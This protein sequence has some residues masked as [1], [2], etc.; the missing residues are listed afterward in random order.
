MITVNKNLNFSQAIDESLEKFSLARKRLFKLWNYYEGRHD[1]L[2]RARRGALPNARLPHGF[3]KYIAEVS[4]GFMLS[5]EPRYKGNCDETALSKLIAFQ[6][7]CSD[8]SLNMSLAIAQS[9]YGLGLSLC[10]YTDKLHMV[11]LDPKNAFVVCDDTAERKPMYGVLLSGRE[12][13]VYTDE[14]VYVFDKPDSK[15]YKYKQRHGFETLP[16]TMYPNGAAMQ[17]D[18]EHVL[19]LI[20]AYDLLASDRI[21]DRAQFADAM[22]V[23]T[24][25]MGLSEDDSDAASRLRQERTLTLPDSDAKAEW[26]I[27]NANEKDVEV[28]RKSIADD[29]HKFSM[30]PEMEDTH[31][32]LG[33]ASG[34]ALQYKLFCLRRR[35]A[36]KERFFIK[37]IKDRIPLICEALKKEGEKAPD[38]ESIE[39]YFPPRD[40]LKTI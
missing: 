34:I 38:P 16:I 20:D 5:D 31:T 37:G 15:S 39:V 19:P 8:P 30:T 21:N 22:L 3:P 18:F 2:S 7:N 36:I 14:Y 24:G 40:I 28:L 29:I 33:S 23:L 6:K 26:L 25:V 11:S 10:F 12:T 27:K 4:A 13:R 32:G 9:V 35:I 1:I 17:G